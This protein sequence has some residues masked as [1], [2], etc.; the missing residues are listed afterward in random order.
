MS[1]LLIRARKHNSIHLSMDVYVLR[2]WLRRHAA[3][4][5]ADF[6]AG[7]TR[8][9]KAEYSWTPVRGMEGRRLLRSAHSTPLRPH[10]QFPKQI[11]DSKITIAYATLRPLN[12]QDKRV[13]LPMWY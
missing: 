1:W 8:D 2:G 6:D 5:E 7:E 12:C 13:P 4:T 10:E 9:S 11:K 3:D